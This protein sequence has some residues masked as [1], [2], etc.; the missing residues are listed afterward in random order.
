MKIPILFGAVVALLGANVYLYMQLD[1]VK[2]DMAGVNTTMQA[3]LDKLQESS[4]VTTRTNSRKVE[5]LKDQLERARRQASLAAGAA[6]DEALKRWLKPARSWKA[7]QL[8]AKT[9]LKAD[10]SQAKEAADT[11]ISAV[12]SRSQ[13]GEK[14]MLPPPKPNWKRL[15]PN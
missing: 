6:K 15:W 5:E 7:A 4:S 13:H 12:G 9:E 2:K 14:P 1:K 8:Q 10:I 11:K 3:Q